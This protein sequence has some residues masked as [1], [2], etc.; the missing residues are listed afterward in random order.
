MSKIIIT[1]VYAR[2]NVGS[3]GIG[4]EILEIAE[5][6][7]EIW[8]NKDFKSAVE[9]VEKIL[10]SDSEDYEFEEDYGYGYEINEEKEEILIYNKM[11]D[12]YGNSWGYEEVLIKNIGPKLIYD[13]ESCLSWIEEDKKYFVEEVD[14]DEWIITTLNESFDLKDNRYLTANEVK[15]IIETF[16]DYIEE[17][18]TAWPINGV[19]IVENN[20]YAYGYDGYDCEIED[21]YLNIITESTCLL[22]AG[23]HLTRGHLVLRKIKT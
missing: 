16:F 11:M 15:K 17:H 2:G 1:E 5:K 7:M 18:F 4:D 9:Y 3:R 21:D 23:Y 13:M 22:G 10:D 12:E 6:V 20:P 14:T 19:P 8:E